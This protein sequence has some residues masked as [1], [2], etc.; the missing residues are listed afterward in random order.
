MESG[1]HKPLEVSGR[2]GFKGVRDWDG[3]AHLNK[4]RRIGIKVEKAHGP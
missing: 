4:P 3:K 1:N 2:P